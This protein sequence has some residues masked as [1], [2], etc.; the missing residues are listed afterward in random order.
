MDISS[1]LIKP[2]FYLYQQIIRPNNLP[3]LINRSRDLVI[4]LVR[5][6]RLHGQRLISAQLSF[7]IHSRY[8]YVATFSFLSRQQTGIAEPYLM[9]NATLANY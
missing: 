1:I 3:P 2:N 5:S 9:T 7:N 4:I 6:R 8:A